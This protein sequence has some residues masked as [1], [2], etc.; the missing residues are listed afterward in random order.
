MKIYAPVFPD[1]LKAIDGKQV[2]IEGFVIPFDEKG[3]IL[4]LSANPYAACFFCG[5]ASPASVLSLYVKKKKRYKMDDFRKFKG[6]LHLNAD[7][8][9]E[10]YYILRNAVPIK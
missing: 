6:V 9:E 1:G 5:K 10:Y 3:D 7:D 4:A 2:I 8:P